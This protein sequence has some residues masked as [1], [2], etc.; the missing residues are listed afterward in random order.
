MSRG[1]EGKS[2]RCIELI[3]LV[4]VLPREQRVWRVL[5]F[6]AFG[7][8]EFSEIEEGASSDVSGYRLSED[9][10]L[11][12]ASSVDQTINA[13]V[14]AANGDSEFSCLLGSG[15]SG[16]FSREIFKCLEV[17]AESNE[18][19]GEVE[20]DIGKYERCRVIIDIHDSSSVTLGINA[21]VPG[22]AG[23]LSAFA[24]I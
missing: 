17:V 18:A 2:K 5:E 19:E 8:R 24:K 9:E 23:T 16:Q 11:E 1:V 15:S 7:G 12:V 14:V 20:V 10:L 22:W 13:V 4:R 3:D 21:D 6:E